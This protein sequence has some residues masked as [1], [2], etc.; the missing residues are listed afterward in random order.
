[1]FIMRFDPRIDREPLEHL[2][3]TEHL[4]LTCSCRRDRP[5]HAQSR[6]PRKEG[7]R[8][9]E[10]KVLPAGLRRLHATQ[11]DRHARMVSTYL[12][13]GISVYTASLLGVLEY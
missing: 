11:T 8:K 3:L 2:Q 7:A 12:F 6:R 4:R 9:P 13:Y 10:L 5:G 1:M